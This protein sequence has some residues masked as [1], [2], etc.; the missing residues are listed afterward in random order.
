[1]I[2]IDSVGGEG[3]LTRSPG[4]PLDL[5]WHCMVSMWHIVAES[6][7]GLLRV[8]VKASH[9][10]F[11]GNRRGGA[12]AFPVEFG[13]SRAVFWKICVFLDCLWS[14]IRKNKLLGGLYR[15][16]YGCFQELISPGPSLGY[17][18][19]SGNIGNSSP[20]HSLGPWV[21]S[22]PSYHLSVFLCLFYI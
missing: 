8:E 19:Q 11:S 17:T 22:L 13:W 15:S 21:L 6:H 20:S 1:M 7:N 18:R 16:V 2:A 9:W 5:L 10:D 4:F 14:L 3:L 12:A